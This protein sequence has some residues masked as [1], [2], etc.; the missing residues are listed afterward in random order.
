[1]KIVRWSAVLTT[2]FA[3]LAF[4]LSMFTVGSPGSLRLSSASASTLPVSATTLRVVSLNIAHG[5]AD[6]FSQLLLDKQQIKH[7]LTAVSQLLNQTKANIVALQEIDSPSIWSGDFDHA[8]YIGQK[9][10]MPNRLTGHHVEGF[11]VAYGTALLSQLPLSNPVS[12]RFEPSPPTFSK[13]FVV[14]SIQWPGQTLMVDVV[15]L[16]LDFSR[17]TVRQAQIQELVTLLQQRNNPVV[18]LGDFNTDGSGDNS[19][20]K[21]LQHALKLKAYAGNGKK[22][23]TFPLTEKRLDWILISPQMSFANYHT[24]PDVVSDHLAVVAELTLNSL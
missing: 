20:L 18:V 14:A 1:M 7:N 11:G 21:T 16:H 5:R 8:D 9:T 22:F 24:L 13:G 10:N 2:A 3:I 6:G 12:Y 19:C 23:E 15:S 4:T 17:S